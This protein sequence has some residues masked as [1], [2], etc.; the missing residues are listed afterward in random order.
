MITFKQFILEK[1][2]KQRE[3]RKVMK[4][5]K[6]ALVGFEIEGFLPKDHEYSTEPT[7]TGTAVR[8]RPFDTLREFEETF[9]ISSNDHECI[10][11]A[12]GEWLAKQED[13]FIEDNWRDYY[14]DD[15]AETDGRRSAESQARVEAKNNFKDTVSSDTWTDWFHDE[16]S[17]AWEFIQEFE[18][19][20]R[21]GWETE[22]GTSS[23]V[24]VEEPTFQS[25]DWDINAARRVGVELENVLKTSVIVTKTIEGNSNKWKIVPDTSIS[26]GVND[27]ES[28][29]GIEIVSPPLSVDEA[30]DKLKMVFSVM[31]KIGVETNKTTGLHVNVSIPGIE[32]LDPVKLILFM[33]D[34]YILKTFNRLENTMTRPH[35]TTIVKSIQIHGS[36]PH[37]AYELIDFAKEAL[38][39]GKYKSV[40]LGKLNEGYLEFRAAGNKDYHYRFDE[41]KELVGRYLTA[42]EVACDPNAERNEYLKKFTKLIGRSAADT[43]NDNEARE[44]SIFDVFKKKIPEKTLLLK[45]EDQN[46]NIKGIAAIGATFSDAFK[47]SFKQIKELRTYLENRNISASDILDFA[48]KHPTDIA[49]NFSK[50]HLD[51]LRIFLKVFKVH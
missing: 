39:K 40:N 16:F 32:N 42:I 9:K 29:V 23:S 33:G 13:R 12:Y 3:Y 20:P 4:R 25:G 2:F 41:I 45:R 48:D 11:D 44:I 17:S 1:A 46:S 28:G 6:G 50:K 47:P 15:L 8:I 14:D 18:L 10:T 34:E 19:Q 27:D 43:L 36:L 49:L 31:Q 37:S 5:N 38:D 24:Y 26:S 30:L 51:N 21:Y 7:K 35:L 22:Y